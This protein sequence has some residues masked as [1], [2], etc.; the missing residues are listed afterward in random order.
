MPEKENEK[1]I[2]QKCKSYMLMSIDRKSDF[3]IWS[4]PKCKDI[5][6]ICP[7]CNGHM[8]I[9]RPGGPGEIWN[10]ECGGI[11]FPLFSNNNNSSF[12]SISCG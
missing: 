6:P 7:R 8:L 2:C 4:C 10:C 12:S 9:E 1:Q 3:F 11:Y 5:I